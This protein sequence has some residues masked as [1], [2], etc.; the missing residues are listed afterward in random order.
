M[1][2]PLCVLVRQLQQVQGQQSHSGWPVHRRDD[3]PMSHS[4]LNSIY[5]YPWKTNT[6]KELNLYF[7]KAVVVCEKNIRVKN[8]KVVFA[9]NKTTNNMVVDHFAK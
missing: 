1:E 6:R 5:K 2:V 3:W 7:F 4:V 9:M 8:E